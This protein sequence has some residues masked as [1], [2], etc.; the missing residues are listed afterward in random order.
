MQTTYM[1]NMLTGI[2]CLERHGL[3]AKTSSTSRFSQKWEVQLPEWREQLAEKG[4]PMDAKPWTSEPAVQT[5]NGRP[6]SERVKGILDAVASEVLGAQMISSTFE[7]KL[8]ALK[9][10]YVDVSQNPCRKAFTSKRGEGTGMNHTLAT[11]T[12]LFSFYR[13]GFL[14]PIEYMYLQGHRRSLTI[15]S[16]MNQRALRT[17]AGEGICVPCLGT[18]LISLSQMNAFG[19]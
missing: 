12:Q 19:R 2:H 3:K 7:E 11:S 9:H 16:E 13:N 5:T 10:T 8:E 6:L 4:I 18:I 17:L 14:V 1:L 15:P